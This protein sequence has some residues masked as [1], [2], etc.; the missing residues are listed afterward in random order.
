M[1]SCFIHAYDWL[2]SQEEILKIY[3]EP[4]Y[5]YISYQKKQLS[6][7][8]RDDHYT[9]TTK[10]MLRNYRS[11]PSIS[12][13]LSPWQHTIISGVDMLAGRVCDFGICEDATTGRKGWKL[14]LF[15]ITR[16]WAFTKRPNRG[17]LL[18][19]RVGGG[20]TGGG[21]PGSLPS[22]WKKCPHR[23][24]KVSNLVDLNIGTVNILTSLS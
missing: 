17:E 14:I 6:L 1:P 2:L 7:T 8:K 24:M 9:H 16:D 4:V 18:G 23:N 19:E 3:I 15:P 10:R 13:S 12:E 5:S 20:A 11:F 22:I 21:L